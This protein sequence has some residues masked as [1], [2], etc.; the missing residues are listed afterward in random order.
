MQPQ[1]KYM[2]KPLLI[3]LA[4]ILIIAAI[5]AVIHDFYPEIKLLIHYTPANR[6][7]LLTMVSSHGL[8]DMV[9]FTIIIALM[10]AI[11]G[12]SNSVVCVFVGLCYGPWL[13]FIVNWLGNIIGN[14]TVA[15]IINRISFS[16]S[17]KKNRI[18]NNLMEMKHPAVGLT[19]GYMVPV[20]PSIIVNYSAVK[21]K[22]SRPAFM[23]MVMVGMLPTSFL[24]AFGGDA[25]FKGSFKRIIV[26]VVAIC[27]LIALVVFFRKRRKDRLEVN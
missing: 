6:Q 11:P 21:L 3:L 2:N 1:K 22:M 25:I 13:G 12:L 27:I 9:L 15:A 19:I 17:F 10:N 4:V 18:L 5:G 8:R 16:R 7:K 24:Y 26:A 20:I 14:C 23:G